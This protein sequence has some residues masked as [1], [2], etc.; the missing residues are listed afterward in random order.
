MGYKVNPD[1]DLINMLGQDFLGI[2]QYQ[3]AKLL[4]DYYLESC[5]ESAAAYAFM[6]DYYQAINDTKNAIAY[7]VKSLTVKEN[8][9]IRKKLEKVQGK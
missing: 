7:F 4:F 8:A 6:G 5:P 9:G 3:K 2:K 1:E